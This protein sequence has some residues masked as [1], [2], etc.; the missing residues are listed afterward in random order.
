MSDQ[1]LPLPPPLRNPPMMLRRHQPRTSSCFA[2][3]VTCAGTGTE[4][5]ASRS[6]EEARGIVYRAVEARDSKWL[7]VKTCEMRSGKKGVQLMCIACF[8]CAPFLALGFL[9]PRCF[10]NG[11]P[12][13]SNI[14]PPEPPTCAPKPSL[15]GSWGSPGAS[16]GPL[17]PSWASRR[18]LWASPEAR[19]N[20]REAILVAT[21]ATHAR[22]PRKKTN[23]S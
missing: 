5:A 20:L 11:R 15:G 3:S 19:S 18:L 6:E 16:W 8:A 7:G 9:L 12:E 13:G 4:S 23:F 22:E 10:E 17:A 1:A 2:L 21:C 14:D